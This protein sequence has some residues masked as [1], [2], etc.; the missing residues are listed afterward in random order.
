M[1]FATVTEPTKAENDYC[2]PPE[3]LDA[4]VWR[5]MAVER[6]ESLLEDGVFFARSHL[7]E[8]QREGSAT[9]R[10]A[11]SRVLPPVLGRPSG[12]NV[13]IPLGEW[14]GGHQRWNRQWVCVS[15]WHMNDVESDAMWKLYVDIGKAVCVQSTFRRLDESL[16][17]CLPGAPWP[18]IGV[19]RYINHATDIIPSQAILAP[20][21]HKPL[22]F[23]HERE[24]R[25]VIW[26]L[27]VSEH[28]IPKRILKDEVAK[29]NGIAYPILNLNRLIER[30]YVAP[31]SSE[32]LAVRVRA[33]ME[34]HQ[35]EAPLLR[36]SLESAAVY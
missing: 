1:F 7:F 32:N 21:F 12:S 6:F 17:S 5:Y 24:L 27:P 23:T 14:I 4:R 18:I 15:C 26:D 13:R 10:Q 3:N 36:S 25:A 8:D 30:V 28:E 16:H 11:W 20:Y 35:I 29:D 31:R 34:V 2:H 33:A 9:H 22:E 19:V